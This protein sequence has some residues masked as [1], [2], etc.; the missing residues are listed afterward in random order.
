LPTVNGIIS[1]TDG[2]ITYMGKVMANLPL[3]P[4]M[5]K[6][7]YFGYIFNILSES[8]IMGKYIYY[9]KKQV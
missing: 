4:P 9:V 3:E 2:D 8:I 7:I 1:T 5:S 6:L